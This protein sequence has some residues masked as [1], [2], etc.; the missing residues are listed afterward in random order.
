MTAR[1]AIEFQN[2]GLKPHVLRDSRVDGASSRTIRAT[3]HLNASGAALANGDTLYIGTRPKGS[4]YRGHRI[5]CGVSLGSS[6]LAIGV[7][8]TTGK[9]RAAAVFTAVD[10]PTSVGLA[11][12]LADDPLADAEDMIVTFAAADLPTSDF[13]LVIETHYSTEND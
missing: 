11:A 8:G 2:D 6:T 7:A 9:Y 13:W 12:R 5:T 10:T 1:R 4:I 3:Y